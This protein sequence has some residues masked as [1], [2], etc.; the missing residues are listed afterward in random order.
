MWHSVSRKQDDWLRKYE[1]VQ[2]AAA[3]AG[4]DPAAIETGITI[5]RPLPESDAES[6]ELHE[7]IARWH[8][9]GV[10]HVV[11]DFGNPASTEPVLRFADQVIARLR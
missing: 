1:I 8:E 2:R 7:L 11:M 4:R 5:E 6:A 9:I 3:D 10:D